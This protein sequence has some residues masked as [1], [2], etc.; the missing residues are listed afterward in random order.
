MSWYPMQERRDSHLILPRSCLNDG[1]PLSETITGIAER[2]GISMGWIHK[3]VYPKL[4]QEGPPQIGGK[5]T[6]SLQPLA[7]SGDLAC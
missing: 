2:F 3:W 6:G 7:R 1:I 4:R 5:L